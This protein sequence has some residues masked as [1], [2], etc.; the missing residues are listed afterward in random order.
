MKPNTGASQFGAS[1]EHRPAVPPI[2]RDQSL[3]VSP[4]AEREVV[5]ERDDAPGLWRGHCESENDVDGAIAEGDRDLRDPAMPART[6]TSSFARRGGR[7]PHLPPHRGQANSPRS[8]GRGSLRGGGRRRCCCVVMDRRLVP[9]AVA[10][11][12]EQQGRRGHA[13]GKRSA[14]SGLY[15][16]R[17]RTLALALGSPRRGVSRPEDHSGIYAATCRCGPIPGTRL[18][19]SRLTSL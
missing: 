9:L 5:T 7:C 17:L 6:P 15:R 8:R 1:Q 12:Q 11:S 2:D 16:S 10:R 13:S 4:A 14:R 18:A 19:N 3:V